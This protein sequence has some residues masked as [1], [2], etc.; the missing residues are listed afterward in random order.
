MK[1][2]ENIP[3]NLIT[4][5]GL[6]INNNNKVLFIYRKNKWDLPKGKLDDGENL[7]E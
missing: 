4:A 5:G 1:S 2:I 7:E 6:V 3:R